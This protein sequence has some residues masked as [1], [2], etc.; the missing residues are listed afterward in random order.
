MTRVQ[1]RVRDL[2]DQARIEIDP[3][4][5]ARVISDADL[6]DALVGAAVS[7]GFATAF[8]DPAGFRSG[9]MNELLADPEAY[10]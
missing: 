3:A 7:A 9:A 4:C 2:G 1:L 6:V 8:V 5:L 10:R